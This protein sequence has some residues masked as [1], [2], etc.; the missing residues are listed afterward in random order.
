MQTIRI[1]LSNLTASRL[2]PRTTVTDHF[3]SQL[4]T[5]IQSY[6]MTTPLAVRENGSSDQYI[7]IDGNTRLTA[8]T[9]LEYSHANCVVNDNEDINDVE[10]ALITNQLRQPIDPW[11]E[12]SAY[13]N[14]I[15]T[16][17][18]NISDVANAFGVSDIHVKQR[19]AL[20]DLDLFFRESWSQNKITADALE[21]VTTLNKETQ[22]AFAKHYQSQES[23]Y[24]I[25]KGEVQFFSRRHTYSAD[26]IIFPDHA[27]VV[28]QNLFGDREEYVQDNALFK[29][30][31][32]NQIDKMHMNLSDAFE[33]VFVD[34][35][36]T[37]GLWQ[38]TDDFQNDYEMVGY[39]TLTAADPLPRGLLS[40]SPFVDER[41][42]D[43]ILIISDEQ[44]RVR[45]CYG[46]NKIL[47]DY[48]SDVVTRQYSGVLLNV[49]REYVKLG[50]AMVFKENPQVALAYLQSVA[51]HG[52][53]AG[54]FNDMD[55]NPDKLITAR[56]ENVNSWLVN[57]RY[58]TDGTSWGRDQFLSLLAARFVAVTTWD[59]TYQWLCSSD[60]RLSIMV[61]SQPTEYLLNKMKRPMLTTIWNEI[62]SEGN[63]SIRDEGIPPLTKKELVSGLAYHCLE[64]EWL[65]PLEELK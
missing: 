53:R 11:D 38:A 13:F 45:V 42:P 18:K 23:E 3:L 51:M 4:K 5:S 50:C 39:D 64:T 33:N 21:Y 41:K 52:G 34:H 58:P 12:C 54:I 30:R 16:D 40:D 8:L 19:L 10:F 35:I 1:P 6:G 57:D 49:A 37:D 36:T 20:A 48:T 43:C 44:M 55:G 63:S 17:G 7:V 47:T 26:D 61:S 9:E 32:L 27:G 31:Q 2:N 62:Y 25:N 24:V 28:S 22:Q 59:Q 65:L 60:A 15:V 14:L 56:L 29:E 46:K